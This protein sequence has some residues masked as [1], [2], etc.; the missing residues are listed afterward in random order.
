[1]IQYIC[2][3]KNC[4]YWF[5]IKCLFNVALIM[6]LLVSLLYL[7]FITIVTEDLKNHDK[8]MSIKVTSTAIPST[9]V[10]VYLLP[11][12]K[13]KVPWPWNMPSFISPSYCVSVGKLYFPFP[14]ILQSKFTRVISVF[15][16]DAI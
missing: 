15:K 6:L 12:G 4:L 8:M 10:A 1:M 2:K 11:F 5:V 13:C 14:S 7:R 9:H 3:E 16:T